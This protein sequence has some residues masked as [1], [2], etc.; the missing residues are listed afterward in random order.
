MYSLRFSYH[1][2]CIETKTL[3]M[4]SDLAGKNGYRLTRHPCV[5]LEVGKREQNATKKRILSSGARG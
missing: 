2:A 5:A 1:A 4:A 3:Q